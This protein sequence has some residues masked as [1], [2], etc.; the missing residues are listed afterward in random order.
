MRF[1]EVLGNVDCIKKDRG[2]DGFGLKVVRVYEDYEPSEV[3][4]AKYRGSEP[5]NGDFVELM[6]TN[7]KDFIITGF[8]DVYLT[9]YGVINKENYLI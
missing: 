8:A 6:Q 2:L 3:I 5:G 9:S 4:V 7:E 1:G